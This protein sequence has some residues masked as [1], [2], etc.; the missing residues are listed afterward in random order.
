MKIFLKLIV[1]AIA[2]SIHGAFA[3]FVENGQV[4]YYS[5]K[6]HHKNCRDPKDP[7]EIQR[8]LDEQR[9]ASARLALRERYDS[10]GFSSFR[11]WPGEIKRLNE[12]IATQ[13][14]VLGFA[15]SER[16]WALDDLRKSNVLPSETIRSAQ[17]SA[18]IHGGIIQDASRKI[19]TYE[20]C[21]ACAQ[22]GAKRYEDCP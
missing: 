22:R 6:F 21:I 16:Q 8:I 3:A 20:W 13:R 4:C 17:Q 2:L 1:V 19:S 9:E 15:A 7:S 14:S 18:S 11:G 5:G 12:L 10:C